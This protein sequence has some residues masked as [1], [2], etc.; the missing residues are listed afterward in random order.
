MKNALN[1]LKLIKKVDR[2]NKKYLAAFA[3]LLD[4]SLAWAD[5]LTGPLAPFSQLY[6]IPIFISAFFVNGKWTYFIAFLAVLA[7]I[8]VFMQL[9][10][11]F[12]LTPVI[13]DFS[14]KLITYFTFAYLTLLLKQVLLKL[15]E[16]AS[17]DSLTK[18]KSGRFFYEVG[19]TELARAYRSKQPL[20]LA[21][22]DLDNFKEVNDTQGHLHGNQLLIEITSS[23]K[24]NLRIE[25]M[26]GRLG[27]DEFAILL[28]QT[29]QQQA[30]GVITRIQQD[31]SKAI[32][33]YKTNVTFSIGVITYLGK[34]LINME[35]FVLLADNAMYD[36]KKTTKNS[37]R[38]LVV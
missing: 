30:E 17:E 2:V 24:T 35:D 34:R 19:A 1:A 36:I 22:I 29:D 5:Y 12:T 11:T 27:G 13:F 28:V 4:L 21:Y 7:D 15:D 26:I 16:L 33:P 25:D 3:L 37:T 6:L 32:T 9:L 38:Y 10:Q 20:S 8:P 23:I 14:S 18:A 31:L